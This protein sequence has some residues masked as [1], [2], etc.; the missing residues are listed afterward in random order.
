M[1]RKDSVDSGGMGFKDLRV[2]N[3]ALLARQAWRLGPS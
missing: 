3:Q 1:V 2:L